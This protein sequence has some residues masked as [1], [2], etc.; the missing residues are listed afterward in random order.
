MPRAN[1]KPV[2]IMCLAEVEVTDEFQALIEK[3][4]G[5]VDNDGTADVIIGAKCWRIDPALGNLDKQLQMMIE[6][7]RAIKYPKKKEEKK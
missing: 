1:P 5:R 3:G 7:V 4:H 6:G 2:N